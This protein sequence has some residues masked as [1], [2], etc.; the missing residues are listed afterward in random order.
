VRRSGTGRR[1]RE[2]ARSASS[3]S[4][5]DICSKSRCCSTSRSETVKVASTSTVGWF[6]L[7]FGRL[8]PARLQRLLQAPAERLLWSGSAGT[9]TCGS[10]ISSS[11]PGGAELRQ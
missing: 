4:A 6:V 8:A 5:W 1:S 9:P 2:M 10:S 11:F 7:F 3:I